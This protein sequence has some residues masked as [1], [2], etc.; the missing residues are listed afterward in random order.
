MTELEK[1]IGALVSIFQNYAGKDGNPNTLNRIEVRE[2]VNTQLPG[3]LKNPNDKE[4][5]EKVM[6]DLNGDGEMDFVEFGQL[7]ILLGA[8]CHESLKN[9]P[10]DKYKA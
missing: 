10:K 5:L 7:V 6:M 9:M 8:F 4:G 2:L 1:C 3:L